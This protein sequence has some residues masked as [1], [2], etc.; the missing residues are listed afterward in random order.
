M[1]R[2][3]KLIPLSRE[4]H[5]MLMLSQ[6]L[7]KNAPLYKGL[8]VSLPDKLKYACNV[9][10][11]T[12]LNHFLREEK[13]LFP[14]VQEASVAVELIGELKSEH[15]I[16]ETEFNKISE[17]VISDKENVHNLAVVL[18]LH[19]R[20]EE[21]QFF[22]IIQNELPVSKLNQLNLMPVG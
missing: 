17:G 5:Q 21:R 4:H 12:I 8:P 22:Q 18:E 6:L 11:D 3:E 14:V 20:K 7:K 13:Y 19:I 2:H 1:R 10:Q 9:Y 16:I 15:R